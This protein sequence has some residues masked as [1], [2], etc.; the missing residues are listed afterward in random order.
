MTPEKNTNLAAI[1]II[2]DSQVPSIRSRHHATYAVVAA[3]I[4]NLKPGKALEINCT[5]LGVRLES[6]YHH[7]KE[8]V[9]AGRLPKDVVT[10]GR[11]TPDGPKLYVVRRAV[12]KENPK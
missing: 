5:D 3:A 6:L 12:K 7:I 11:A 4:E 1:R 9:D 10:A 8:A 2:P